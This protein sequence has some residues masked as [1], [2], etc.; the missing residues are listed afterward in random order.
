VVPWS[1]PVTPRSA[2]VTP[3]LRLTSKKSPVKCGL[4]RCYGSQPPNIPSL[5]LSSS[6]SSSSSSSAPQPLNLN[7]NRHLTLLTPAAPIAPAPSASQLQI[8]PARSSSP[9]RNPDPSGPIDTYRDPSD[10]KRISRT[11]LHD[12]PRVTAGDKNS[13]P[14][15]NQ[16]PQKNFTCK[17]RGHPSQSELI[18]LQK[19]G[20]DPLRRPNTPA[21]FCGLVVLW[22]VVCGLVVSWS[23]SP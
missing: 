18:R 23:C 8:A 21:K 19:P 7:L 2:L 10:K 20:V 11:R 6:F 17:D 9:S 5:S 14:V 4:L 15:R 1:L 12:I 16:H 22:S 3:L 13:C